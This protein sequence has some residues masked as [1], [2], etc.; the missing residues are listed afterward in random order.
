[1]VNGQAGLS[2]HPALV[3]VVAE[4]S[5]ESGLAQHRYLHLV[6]SHV[7]ARQ[8]RLKL[9]R[10]GTVVSVTFVLGICR[11]IPFIQPSCKQ[12]KAVLYISPVLQGGGG[13][14]DR[15]RR[16]PQLI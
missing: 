16:F 5:R 6:E 9:A 4:S 12:K 7:W 13:G 15:G 3:H 10:L 11:L 14:R 1:M 8:K 2:G